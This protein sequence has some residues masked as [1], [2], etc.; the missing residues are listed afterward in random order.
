MNV[1]RYKIRNN[2]TNITGGTINPMLNTATG[3]Q[4]FTNYL[5]V[6][7]LKPGQNNSAYDSPLSK[8]NNYFLKPI[9]NNLKN[10]LE[11]SVSDFFDVPIQGGVL[12]SSGTTIN[13][14]YN[15]KNI[16]I[17]INVNIEPGDY[18]DD[19]DN[20]IEREK[21]KNINPMVDGEKVKYLTNNFIPIK[22]DFRF[23][24]KSS[25]SFDPAS[26]NGY[27]TA[28]FLP[29]EIGLKNNFKKSFFRLYFYDNNDTKTQNLLLTEDISTFGTTIPSFDLKKIFWLKNDTLFSGVTPT[30]RKVY[31]EARFFNAK[32]G[33]V[34][35]FINTPLTVVTPL[36]ITQFA[37]NQPWK[38]SKMLIMNPNANGGNKLF[39]VDLTLPNGANLQNQITFTE[40]ILAT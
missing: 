1:Y 26:P 5:K 11:T 40:Y 17:P 21:K 4:E 12:I 18:S 7:S 3:T 13:P 16:T 20:F 32:T 19:I 2:Y 15:Y 27:L 33:R 25:N 29:E 35:R 6:Y 8:G 14:N 37:N 31:V 34:H 30:S 22:I 28:G 36:T 38:S 39:K 24:N 23:Y 9:F 10:I